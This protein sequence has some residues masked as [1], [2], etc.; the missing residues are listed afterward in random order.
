MKQ[1]ILEAS[2]H[3]EQMLE[4]RDRDSRSLLGHLSYTVVPKEFGIAPRFR[5]RSNEGKT[6]PTASH[7]ELALRYH[8]GRDLGKT[9][10]EGY[11][12]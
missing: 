7:I 4:V 5:F 3:A 12:V 8:F 10:V 9:H 2:P 1:L 11:G 6:T